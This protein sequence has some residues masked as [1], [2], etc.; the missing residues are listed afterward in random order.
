VLGFIKAEKGAIYIDLNLLVRQYEAD[1]I[2]I[3]APSLTFRFIQ[4]KKW[5]KIEPF[6]VV[7]IFSETENDA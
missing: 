1:E 6:I 3:S 4:S 7:T 5:S 2:D